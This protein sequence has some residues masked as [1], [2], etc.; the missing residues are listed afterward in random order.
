MPQELTSPLSCNSRRGV[1]EGVGTTS[2]GRARVQDMRAARKTQDGDTRTYV[3]AGL[4]MCGVCDR[5]FDSHWVHERPGYRCR[6]GRTSARTQAP[7]PKSTYVREDHL[8]EALRARL[9]D[10]IG[11][12]EAAA[13]DYLRTNGLVI[14][15]FGLDWTVE[16]GANHSSNR[17]PAEPNAVNQPASERTRR[18]PPRTDGSNRAGHG[19]L[20]IRSEVWFSRS[21]D[22][23]AAC[24]ADET[25]RHASASHTNWDRSG[26][27]L[28]QCCIH[29]LGD[30]LSP[31]YAGT[32]PRAAPEGPVF[33]RRLRTRGD[34]S[35]GIGVLHRWF[36]V[37]MLA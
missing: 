23:V 17:Q 34:G 21:W 20:R 1:S 4:I 15:H 13:S 10:A 18:P 37:T 6:H 33:R 26:V 31:A 25:P 30:R 19:L 12:D 35:S 11:N 22:F 29:D 3:L 7:V 16:E 2:R 14:V 36:L 32:V 5:R 24:W 27:L 9:A 8:L 28:D